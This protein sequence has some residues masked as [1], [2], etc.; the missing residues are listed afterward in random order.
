MVEVGGNLF[1]EGKGE[2][3]GGV[4]RRGRELSRGNGVGRDDRQ[5]L[6]VVNTRILN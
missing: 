1:R 2:S 5:E 6:K 3:S 4:G